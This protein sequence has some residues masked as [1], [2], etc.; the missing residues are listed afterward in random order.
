MENKRL[1]AAE[2]GLARYDGAPCIH[3][4]G[5]E[6]YTLTNACVICNR[7]RVKSYQAR[8]REQVRQARASAKEQE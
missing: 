2:Q 1:R 7:N 3:G 4:H 8:M 6:R 5:T